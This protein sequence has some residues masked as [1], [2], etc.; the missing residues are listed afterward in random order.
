MAANL[1]FLTPFYSA[2]IPEN[3]T[4]VTNG[5]YSFYIHNRCPQSP[6]C[7][8][9]TLHCLLKSVPK[10]EVNGSKFKTWVVMVQQALSGTL[11][12]GIDLHSDQLMLS[13]AEDVLLKMASTSTIDY[14]IK[15]ISGTFSVCSRTSHLS[16]AQE[17]FEN[18]TKK[19]TRLGFLPNQKAM[20]LAEMSSPIRM[21][22]CHI[23][24]C[25]SLMGLFF[26][27]SLP[28][29]ESYPFVNMSRHQDF[30]ME[31]GDYQ[32]KNTDLLRIAKNKLS[33]FRQSKH[34]NNDCRY[35]QSLSTKP[36]ETAQPNYASCPP[37]TSSSHVGNGVPSAEIETTHSLI[38]QKRL[39]HHQTTIN[40][41]SL[42]PL[43]Q[44]FP[45]IPPIWGMYHRAN[46][47]IQPFNQ[48]LCKA[49]TPTSHKKRWTG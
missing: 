35:D 30:Q 44:P 23:L 25:D 42:H 22:Q 48:S 39:P 7:N 20:R 26:Q 19:L 46:Q 8:T 12:C 38:L 13:K 33:L 14:G 4:N 41:V 18:L 11:L 17:K 5:E 29:P 2:V 27:L 32:V 47:M 45:S 15:L 36:T 1:P 16:I 40:V 9:A 49:S 3:D 24:P 31:T 28:N 43:S 34:P 6:A 10:L 37:S 21:L